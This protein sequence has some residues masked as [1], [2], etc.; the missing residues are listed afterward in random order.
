MKNL[1]IK[2][3]VVILFL[4][5]STLVS[6]AQKREN[7]EFVKNMPVYME[8]LIADLDYPLA[9]GNSKIKNFKKW[10]KTAREKVFE[11]MLT[12]PPPAATY[13]MEVLAE[14]QRRTP[15]NHVWLSNPRRTDPRRDYLPR[16]PHP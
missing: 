13:D 12:P 2:S 10:K 8:Q 7:H 11:C 15:H 1:F 9:W 3:L 5:T 4:L 6:H 16:H 14:E